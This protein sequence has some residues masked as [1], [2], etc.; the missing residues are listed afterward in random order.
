MSS[1]NNRT[2]TETGIIKGTYRRTGMGGF[3]EPLALRLIENRLTVV[4]PI[5]KEFSRSGN[6]G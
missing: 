3:T 6:H 5:R 4:P 1:R 2:Q